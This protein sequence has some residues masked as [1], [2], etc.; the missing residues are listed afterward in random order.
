MLKNP[1]I[2]F[3]SC[4]FLLSSC[5]T[6]TKPVYSSLPADEVILAFGDS[7]THGTGVGDDDSY[8]TILKSL[9]GFTVINAGIPGE[10]SSIG[11]IHLPEL[12]DRNDW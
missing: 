2:F 4:Y 3:I 8:P 5:S 1:L 12:L 9:T 10:V 11:L 7:L 6:E